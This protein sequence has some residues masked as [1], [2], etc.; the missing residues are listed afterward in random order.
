MEK[1]KKKKR[2]NILRDNIYSDLFQVFK[3]LLCKR[4]L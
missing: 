1:K 4:F 2:I 3:G